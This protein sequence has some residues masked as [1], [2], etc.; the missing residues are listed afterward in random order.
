MGR[1][2]FAA[3][4][5]SRVREKSPFGWRVLALG[6][7]GF[8]SNVCLFVCLYSDW[9]ALIVMKRVIVFEMKEGEGVATN[10]I[11]FRS[12]T[13]FCEEVLEFTDVA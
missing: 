3:T 13:L 4:F 8:A 11:E 10:R 7:G 12:R 5:Y 2:F 6:E 9:C 1:D